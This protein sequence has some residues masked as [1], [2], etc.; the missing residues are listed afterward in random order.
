M[1]K[2][3]AGKWGSAATRCVYGGLAPQFAEGTAHGLRRPSATDRTPPSARINLAGTQRAVRSGLGECFCN[4]RGTGP[5][6]TLV[7]A[8]ERGV[9]SPA[10]LKEYISFGNANVLNTAIIVEVSM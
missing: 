1:W 7:E 6:S 3:G 5:M 4:G 10:K 2:A 8:R 9:F